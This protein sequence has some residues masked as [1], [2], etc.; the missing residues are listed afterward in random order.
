MNALSGDITD[1]S[2]ENVQS[3]VVDSG[4]NIRL[5]CGNGFSLKNVRINGVMGLSGRE[6]SGKRI[7]QNLYKKR[8]GE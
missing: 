6:N 7:Y 5:L 8:K 4:N 3:R 2:I 1:I